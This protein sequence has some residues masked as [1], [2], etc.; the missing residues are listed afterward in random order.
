MID[1]CILGATGYGGGE[2][3]RLL[4]GHPEV[5]SLRGTSRSLAGKPFW[6]KHPNLRGVADGAFEAEPPFGEWADAPHPVLFSALPHGELAKQ[7]A[8]LEA[9][10]GQ[11]GLA[12]RLL[13]VDLSGDFRLKDPVAFERAYGKVHPYPKALGSFVYGLPEWN[14]KALPGA[15][16]IASAGCFATALQI[17]LLPLRGLDPGFIGASAVT[18][19]SGS[20]A[21]HSDTTHHPTRAQDFRAYKVLDH[22]HLPEVRAMMVACGIGG[23]LAFVPQSAPMVRGIFASLQFPLPAG[24]DAK[25]LR[26]R[27]EAAFADAPFVRLVE[28]TPRVAAVTG[29]NFCDVAVTARDGAGVVMTALDNLV[30]GMAGQAIQCMNLALELD[31]TTGLKSAGCYP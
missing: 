8:G 1:V 7:L 24:L 12:D 14:K 27:A 21:L 31:E 19:S 18:G 11:Q 23:S 30:K 15:K 26:A 5:R 2:L 22:Q 13:L 3:L 25:G 17:A 9:Q 6:S 16:R 10:I 29:S 20:G 4:G 28:G